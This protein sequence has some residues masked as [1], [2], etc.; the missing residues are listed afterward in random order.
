MRTTKGLLAVAAMALA[1][2]GFASSAMAATDG[3]LR[4]VLTNG[5]IP[6]NRELHSVGY[7]KFTSSIGST[8]CHVTSI[9]KTSGTAGT[10][11]NMTNYSIPDLTK[12]TFTG[13][14]AGC[15]LTASATDNLPYGVTVTPTDFDVTGSI[16]LTETWANGSGSCP[17]AGSNTL[18]ATELTLKPLKTGTRVVTDT[19][20]HLG[21]TAG[22]NEPI[23]GVE[24]SGSMVL[25]TAFFGNVALT[26]SGEFELTEPDRCTWKISAS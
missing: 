17:I 11:G 24:M 12:C 5:I 8:E 14:L 3:V 15:K 23:A 21:E 4:D 18:T 9:I 19:S 7:M 16:L 10:S 1:L 2:M 25:H 6:E 22:Q 26:I 20:G 13:T